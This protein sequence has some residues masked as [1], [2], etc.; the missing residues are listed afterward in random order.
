MF[1][2]VLHGRRKEVGEQLNREL[3]LTPSWSFGDTPYN[4]FFF[5]ISKKRN[6]LMCIIHTFD[7]PKWWLE[8]DLSLRHLELRPGS[9][10]CLCAD[11]PST[12]E[13]AQYELSNIPLEIP[14]EIFC[15]KL[16]FLSSFILHFFEIDASTKLD[17]LTQ[18]ILLFWGKNKT[19]SNFNLHFLHWSLSRSWISLWH[20]VCVLWTADS[21]GALMCPPSDE[22]FNFCAYTVE[23]H[24]LELFKAACT[25]CKKKKKKWKRKETKVI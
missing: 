10:P 9:S 21:A 3:K 19:K 5:L 25:F 13:R 1:S 24:G 2:I 18:S 14:V 8:M 6:V 20:S 23:Q 16:M 22:S 17:F 15:T 11:T 12:L 4:A 7:F